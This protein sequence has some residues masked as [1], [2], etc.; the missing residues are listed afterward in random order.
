MP[1]GHSGLLKEKEERMDFTNILKQVTFRLLFYNQC[2]FTHQQLPEYAGS[3][4]R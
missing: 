4:K 1:F 3:G 2:L